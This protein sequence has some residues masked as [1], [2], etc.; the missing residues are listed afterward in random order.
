MDEASANP[1]VMALLF[2]GR[3]LVPVALLL[4]ISYLLRRFGLIQGPPE[5]ERRPEEPDERAEERVS[6]VQS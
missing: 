2:I 3:C 6:N 4:G 5:E 1:I